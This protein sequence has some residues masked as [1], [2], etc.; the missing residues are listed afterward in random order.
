MQYLA[1]GAVLNDLRVDLCHTV[2]AVAGDDSQMRHA[3]ALRGA[4]LDDAEVG[5]QLAVSRMTA[6]KLGLVKISQSREQQ[7]PRGRAG[8]P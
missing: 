6:I 4:L 7:R 2:D 5:L 3:D 1:E 8:V